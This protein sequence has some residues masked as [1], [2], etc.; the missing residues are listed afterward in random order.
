MYTAAP[1]GNRLRC[2]TEVPPPANKLQALDPHL[3]TVVLASPKRS[4]LVG[5][6]SCD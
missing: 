5:V 6:V 3:A 1:L 2:T 4:T